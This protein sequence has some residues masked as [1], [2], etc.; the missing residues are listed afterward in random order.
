M[1]AIQ[2]ILEMVV[3]WLSHRSLTAYLSD[4]EEMC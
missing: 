3:F 2:F 1:L 4:F